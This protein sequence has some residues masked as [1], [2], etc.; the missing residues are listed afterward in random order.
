MSLPVNATID[1]WTGEY[2]NAGI[3]TLF[4]VGVGS[5]AKVDPDGLKNSIV[6]AMNNFGS[7]ADKSKVLKGYF[8]GLPAELDVMNKVDVEKF[9]TE[10]IGAF[11]KSN[12]FELAQNILREKIEK[13]PDELGITFFDNFFNK[14]VPSTEQTL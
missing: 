11:Q 12:Q 4:D 13:M 1:A 2:D 7:E 3:N 8:A 6:A 10:R 9:I 5:W 14:I